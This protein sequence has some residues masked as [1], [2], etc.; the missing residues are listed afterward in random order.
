MEYELDKALLM[1]TEVVNILNVRR[2]MVYQFMQ[3]GGIYTIR[4]QSWKKSSKD[5]DNPLWALFG[6]LLVVVIIVALVK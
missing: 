2:A 5:N 1:A 4:H 3:H 6:L